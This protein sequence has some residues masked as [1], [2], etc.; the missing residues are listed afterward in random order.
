MH[1]SSGQPSATTSDSVERSIYS[2]E[3]QMTLKGMFRFELTS[4]IGRI[5]YGGRPPTLGNHA[6]LLNLGC[7]SKFYPEFINADFFRRRRRPEW[8]FW[9]LDLR[10][11]LDCPDNHWDG[12]YTE[13][14]MEHLHPAD[15]LALLREV[16]RTMKPGAVLRV[17]VPDLGK[18]VDYYTGRPSHENFARWQPRGAALRSVSQHYLHFALWDKELMTDCL[19][20][21]GFREIALCDFGRGSDGRLIKDTPERAYESL[22][23]E[24]KK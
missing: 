10:Y 21:A 5:F 22:Y 18:Y 1:P 19:G 14:T 7:G 8:N 2:R 16:H 6:N 3:Y 13:H 11:P 23:L 12:V 4:M 20:R 9:G 24:A 15:G 17:I